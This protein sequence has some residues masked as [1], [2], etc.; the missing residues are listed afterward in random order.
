ME[1]NIKEYLSEEEIKEA[2]LCALRDGVKKMFNDEREVAR[3]LSNVSYYTIFNEIDKIVPGCK[4]KIQE[5][6]QKQIE[7]GDYRYHVFREASF[8]NAGGEGARIAR[9]YVYSRREEIMAK[10]QKA[11][12]DYDVKPLV[13]KMFQRSFNDLADR[14]QNIADMLY[15]LKKEE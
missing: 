1:I 11:I 14:F 6:I 9:E 12:D 7:D 10:V 5:N 15:E 3:I 4:D 2:I 13:E 8:G